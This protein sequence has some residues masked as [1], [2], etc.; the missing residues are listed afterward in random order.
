MKGK[1]VRTVGRETTI[2]QGPHRQPYQPERKQREQPEDPPL[3][4]KTPAAPYP[5]RDMMAQIS[6][7]PS[8]VSV[9][10]K[11]LSYAAAAD[12]A[13]VH[14]DRQLSGSFFISCLCW[15]RSV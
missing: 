2:V 3:F 7:T 15:R 4:R 10:P 11:Y 8:T 1:T 9:H 13:V 12:P 14:F 5:R 6:I